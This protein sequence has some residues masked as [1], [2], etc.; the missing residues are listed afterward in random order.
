MR[1]RVIG[2]EFEL[3]SI[4]EGRVHRSDMHKYASGRAALYQILKSIIPAP[5]KVWL[6]DWLC[7]SMIDAVSR[8]GINYS[9]YRLG[10][11]YRMD[12]QHFLDSNKFVGRQEA[13]LLVNYFGLTDIEKTIQE[14]RS[15]QVEAVIIE[16]DVQAFFS[17]RRNDECSAD[18]RFTSLRKTI[19]SPDGGMVK[20]YRSMIPPLNDNTFAP[21]KLKGALVKGKADKET[22]DS[23]YLSLFEKGEALIDENYESGMSDEGLRI[24]FSTDFDMVAEK[25]MTNAQFLV[26]ELS[27]FG[28][29]PLM[30]I[31]SEAVPLFVPIKIDRRDEVR[32]ALRQ[33]NIFCPVH[34]P[35]RDD[36][37]ELS[38]G[39]EMAEKEL[40]VVI[41]QRYTEEDMASIVDVIKDTLW[42]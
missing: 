28:I 23:E 19:A 39:T 41:D 10:S 3:R 31:S 7:K 42:R 9:F 18:Y 17:F 16:D 6:P 15:S 35:L 36:M 12:V 22:D 37:K 40:S 25:R 4:P 20:T 11:D 5:V 21:F 29:E 8:A 13:I 1:S 2:G 26:K 27:Q 32:K 38:M 30:P 14:L 24:Y 33:H 34:W